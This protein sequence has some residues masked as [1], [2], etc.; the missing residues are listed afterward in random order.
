MSRQCRWFRFGV[1]AGKCIKFNAR[2]RLNRHFCL[3]D[4]DVDRSKKCK[5]YLVCLDP[6]SPQKKERG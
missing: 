4:C 3:Y 2:S 1:F 6:L 5:D